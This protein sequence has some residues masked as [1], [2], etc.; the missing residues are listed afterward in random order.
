MLS[1]LSTQQMGTEGEPDKN[2]YDFSPAARAT[3]PANGGK[4]T[5]TYRGRGGNRFAFN[6]MMIGGDYDEVL[7][8]AETNGGQ[9]VLFTDVH[10]SALRDLF[11]HRRLKGLLY[12]A[13]NNELDLVLTN[14]KSSDATVNIKMNGFNGQARIEE[15]EACL[16]RTY[17]YV[18]KPKLLFGR[19]TLAAGATNQKIEIAGRTDAVKFRRYMIGATD[20]KKIRAKLM[21]YEDTVREEVYASQV[22]D[23]FL[24]EEANQPYQLDANVS[25]DL[26]TSNDG[27]A[28]Q[29]VSAVFEAYVAQ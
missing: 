8:R 21:L 20:L 24:S 6:A 10:L 17:G 11:L 29:D 14:P 13:A 19:A 27:Q 16:R 4:K 12:V 22:R 7:C 15:Q 2:T 5:L 23:E 26:I 3:I 18:P 25:L 28:E 1:T 9:N